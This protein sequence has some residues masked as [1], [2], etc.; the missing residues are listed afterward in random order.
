MEGRPLRAA[1]LHISQTRSA[2]L[3]KRAKKVEKDGRKNRRLRLRRLL[4]VFRPVPFLSATPSWVPGRG[5]RNC[6][7]KQK[8]AKNAEVVV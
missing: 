2:D 1:G 4:P 6:R 3:R 7:K 5:E 8:K